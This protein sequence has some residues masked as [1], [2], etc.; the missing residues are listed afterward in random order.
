M[1]KNNNCSVPLTHCKDVQIR[2]MTHR[3]VVES[4]FQLYG[5]TMY[6][7]IKFKIFMK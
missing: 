2:E 3:K 4:I 5:S 7:R 6:Y 1:L